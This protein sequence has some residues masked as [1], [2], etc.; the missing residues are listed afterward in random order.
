MR[1]FTA[2]PFYATDTFQATN[3][4][5]VTAGLRWEQPGAG[6]EEN[7]RNSVLKPDPPVTIWGYEFR[8]KSGYRNV[9]P[10]D[11]WSSS[12]VLS[13]LPAETRGEE[14]AFLSPFW[15]RLSRHP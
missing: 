4:L 11:S 8:H 13:I 3:K 6:S 12:P 5:T 9:V 15:L 1:F 2:M 10:R 14:S 7:E